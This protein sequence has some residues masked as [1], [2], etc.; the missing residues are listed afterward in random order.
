MGVLSSKD[1]SASAMGDG[2][3]ADMQYS[4]NLHQDLYRRSLDGY[5]TM[6]AEQNDLILAFNDGDQNH[7]LGKNDVIGSGNAGNNKTEELVSVFRWEH[8]G[9]A[10]FISGTFNGWKKRFQCTAVAMIFLTFKLLPRGKYIYKFLVDEWRFS[11]D[12]PTVADAQG[13]V[14]NMLDLTNFR[15]IRRNERF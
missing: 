2:G 5:D 8:G 10:V 3:T 7:N 14:N 9:N 15:Y 11:P 12:Q 13:N 1:G 4:S 6:N